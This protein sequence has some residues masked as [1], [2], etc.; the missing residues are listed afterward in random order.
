L[1]VFNLRERL[2]SDY[3]SYVK[4]FIN[5]RDDRLRAFVNA[6]LAAGFLRPDPLIHLNPALAAKASRAAFRS[7]AAP[8]KKK[9]SLPLIQRR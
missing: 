3:S 7:A 8:A 2:V 4:S 1:D 9:L 5:I 6:E